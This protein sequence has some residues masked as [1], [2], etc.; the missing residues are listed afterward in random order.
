ML[1]AVDLAALL[2]VAARP[3]RGTRHLADRHCE[4]VH[5]TVVR[6][7]RPRR[8]L[9]LLAWCALLLLFWKL[10]KRQIKMFKISFENQE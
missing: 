9:E 10:T 1:H 4:Y 7:Q 5:V 2:C 6:L 3:T 8:R